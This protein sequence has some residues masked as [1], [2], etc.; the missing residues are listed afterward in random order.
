MKLKLDKIAI[1]GTGLMGGSLGRTLLKNKI[2]KQVVGWGR[3]IKKLKKALSKKVVT[4]ITL[5]LK[6][7]VKDADVVL[8]SLPVSIIPEYFK[9]IYPYLKRK[10]IVTDMGSV[11][12]KI[13]KEIKKYDKAA[14]FIGSHPMVGS[15]KTGIDNIKDDLYKKG[16]CIITPDK[17]T[18]KTKLEFLKLFWK[19]VGMQ[20]VLLNPDEHDKYISGISH[21]P[22][23]LAYLL[24]LTQEQN[25][26]KRKEI[27]GRG[28]LDTTRIAA[29]SEEIW[30]DI[31]FDNKNNLLSDIKK[32][33]EKLN[34][35]ELLLR[36]NEKE[37]IKKLLRKAK[38][39]R[40]KLQ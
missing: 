35:F 7:A 17:T 13:I 16:V 18:D 40:G 22:H 6:T 28:F 39:L 4:D 32:Y 26:I 5:D 30:T 24:T 29:S 33:K 36:K 10:C 37:K 19:K 14:Y 2:S 20:T 9:K 27:I 15:E 25:I 8:I 3:N 11:K 12:G 34:E 31:F 21:L 38:F 23:L 1:L